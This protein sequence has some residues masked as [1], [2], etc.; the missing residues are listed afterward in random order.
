MASFKALGSVWRGVRWAGGRFGGDVGE[1]EEHRVR[2]EERLVHD[3]EGVSVVWVLGRTKT[4]ARMGVV[5]RG[6][7]RI[8]SLSALLGLVGG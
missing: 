2:E 4:P 3:G 8:D 1:Q 5:V 7:D 6:N